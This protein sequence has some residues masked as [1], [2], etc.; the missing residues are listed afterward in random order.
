[1]KRQR[2]IS[3]IIVISMCL[4]M[5]PTWAY[6]EN[7]TTTDP[8]APG[9]TASA[10]PTGTPDA[11]AS[12]SPTRDPDATAG[13]S[14]TAS[15]TGTPDATASASKTPD[16]VAGASIH[17]DPLFGGEEAK[18]L[19]KAKLSEINV[20]EATH[21]MV[22][23]WHATNEKGQ[24]SEETGESRDLHSVII[25]GYIVPSDDSDDG[26]KYYAAARSGYHGAEVDNGD[27]FI[28]LSPTDKQ[29]G[30][31]WSVY[32]GTVG[33][34]SI[35][36]MECEYGN[37]D[38]TDEDEAYEHFAGFN[39]SSGANATVTD[40]NNGD[41]IKV[42]YDKDVHIV[43]MH[44]FYICETMDVNGTADKTVFGNEGIEKSKEHDTA[45][46][47]TYLHDSTDSE[48]S[49]IKG[50]IVKNG[51][52]PC[53]KAEELPVGLNVGEDVE[54]TKVYSTAVGLHTD[55]TAS[56]HEEYV[57]DEEGNRVTDDDGHF[58]KT[59]GDGRTFNVDLESWYT[60]GYAQQVGMVIDASG[61]MGFAS[62]IPNAINVKD[63]IKKLKSSGREADATALE[64][65]IGMLERLGEYTKEETTEYPSKANLKGYY[66]FQPN[67]DGDNRTWF[68]NTVKKEPSTKYSDMVKSDFAKAVSQPTDD[69]ID[70]GVSNQKTLIKY[71]DYTGATSWGGVPLNFSEGQGF[72]LDY[73]TAG[74]LVEET[75][76]SD[77]FTLSFSLNQT[78][79][80][81]YTGKLEILYIGGLTGSIAASKYFHVYR[82]G[83]DI[84]AEL[85]KDSKLFTLSNVYG[86]IAS[87][88]LAF[89]FNNGS[90]TAYLDGAEKATASVT[91]LSG[92]NVVFAPFDDGYKSEKQYFYVDN[93]Y[94]YDAALT[95][96]EIRTL[97]S[98]VGQPLSAPKRMVE[99][100]LTKD[101]QDIILNPRNTDNSLLGASGY[102]Y[103]VY[104]ARINTAE[105]TP[106]CYYAGGAPEFQNNINGNGWYYSSYTG[107]FTANSTT[108][109][110]TIGLQSGWTFTDTIT[111][112]TSM[113][114]DDG[115]GVA[116]DMTTESD[117]GNTGI[118]YTVSANGPIKFYIDSNGY[119]RC[120]TATG[121]SN[122]RAS[123][124]YELTDEQYVKTEAL[125]RAVGA[126][127]TKMGE[128]SPSAIVSAVRFSS[129]KLNE[130]DAILL[131][132]TSN[133]S[134]S[135]NTVSTNRGNGSFYAKDN[136]GQSNYGLTGG[137]SSI[138]GLT[139]FQSKL[140]DENSDNPDIPKYLIIFT[141]GADDNVNEPDETKNIA[142]TLKE[143]GYTIF[144]VLLNGGPV[145]ETGQQYGKAHD[146]LV[147]LSGKKGSSKADQ[148]AHFFSVAK[149]KKEL[150]DAAKGMNDADILTQIFAEE[151]LDQIIKP[152]E[153]FT[154]TEYIDP[155]FDLVDND[156]TV[157]QLKADGKVVKLA[158]DGKTE[159]IDVTTGQDIK[160]ELDNDNTDSVARK[161]Y[162]RYDS[163]K[164]ESENKGMY[165]LEWNGQTIPAS[166]IGVN[167]LAIWNARI[168]LR[169]KENFV[170]GN[171]IP[172]GGNEEMQNFVRHKTDKEPHSDAED[173]IRVFDDETGEIINHPSKGFPRVMVNVPNPANGQNDE[174]T[175]FMGEK[176]SLND[177]IGQVMTWEGSD[178]R[179]DL[180]SGIYW[181][182]ILRYTF[183][184]HSSM[185]YNDL[186]AVFETAEDGGRRSF[187]IPYYYLPNVAGNSA[188]ENK[189][190]TGTDLHR[191]DRMGYLRYTWQVGDRRYPEVTDSNPGELVRDTLPRQSTLS[192]KFTPY[193]EEQRLG[194][195]TFKISYLQ[196]L[197]KDD[198]THII[199]E[200]LLDNV[201]KMTLTNILSKD[202][203]LD[204]ELYGKVFAEAKKRILDKDG[205]YANDDKTFSEVLKNVCESVELDGGAHL[206]ETR[207]AEINGKIDANDIISMKA[208][209]VNG[210]DNSLIKDTAYRWDTAYK[211]VE[212]KTIKDEAA[213]KDTIRRNI[214]SGKVDLR[215][216]VGA[217]E[218]NKLLENDIIKT[219]TTI[220]YTADLYR[221]GKELGKLTANYTVKGKLTEDEDI[222]ATLELTDEQFIHDYGT[223]EY[224]NGWHRDEMSVGKLTYDVPTYGLPKGTYTIKNMKGE[225]SSDYLDFA[226]ME[227]AEITS[228]DAGAI[229]NANSGVL[230]SL[231]RNDRYRVGDKI[232]R[233]S[234][235]TGEQIEVEL[236]EGDPEVGT[237]KPD[238]YPDYSAFPAAVSGSAASIGATINERF[239]LFNVDIEP[240]PL[241]SLTVSKTVTGT[242]GDKNKEFTFTLDVHD[243]KIDGEFANMTFK[244]GKA[245]FKL[246]DGQS[247][248]ITLP[249]G[250]K[251]TV[252]ESNNDGYT[253]TTKGD[254]TG[255]IEEDVEAE[256]E[257]E[258][259]LDALG[260]LTVSKTVKGDL[261]D[262]NKKFGF[263]VVL[264]NE[265]I[266]GKYGDMTFK[267]GVTEFELKD[268][269]SKTAKNLPAGITY[270]VVESVTDKGDYTVDSI[271]ASG[272]IVAG[273][274]AEA[275]F[276]NT[277]NAPVPDPKG[278]LKISKTV[279]GTAGNKNKNFKF[280]LT[281]GDKSINGELGGLTFVDGVAEF[282]LKDNESITAMLP[283][284]ITYKV[285]EDNDGYDV[286][287]TGVEGTI[288][289]KETVTAEFINKLDNP[290]SPKGNLTVS[291]TVTGD[292]GEQNKYFNFIV[293]LDDESINGEYG[294]MTFENGVATF[295]L[296]HGESIT[297]TDLPAGITYEVKESET[298]RGDYTAT[299]SDDTGT[300]EDGKT[301][302]AKF[303]N[304]FNAVVPDPKGILTVSKTVTG[305]GDKT[306]NFTFTLTLGDESING[307]FGGLTFVN[308]VTEFKLK[309]GEKQIATLP[310][311]IT[312]KVEE[313]DNDG[314][315][316]TSSGD[317]TGMIEPD[318]PKEVKF[319]NHKSPE[320]SPTPSPEVSPK[321]SPEVSPTP[322]PEVS[323]KP[324]PSPSP[325]PSPDR[326]PSRNNSPK[327]K[328]VD[329][330]YISIRVEKQW[331][332]NN[333]AEGKRPES[334]TVNVM[335]GDEI[336]ATH[337]LSA[338]NNWIYTF[339]KLAR[340]ANG[341]AINYTVEEEPVSG[342]TP[343]YVKSTTGYIIRN[344]YTGEDGNTR[345]G[346]NPN[347]GKDDVPELNH[348]DHHAYIIGYPEGDVRPNNQITRAEVATIFFRLLTDDSRSKYWNQFNSF[349]DVDLINWYNNGVSTMANA[350]IVSGYLDGT[351]LPNAPI[352][353]AEFAS[354]A[355]RF[356]SGSYEGEDKFTDISDHWAKEYINRAAERGWISGYE[357]GTFRPTQPIIRSEAMTLI[358]NMLNR[359]PANINAL[360]EGMITWSD[361]LD[362][363]AWY[364]SAVQEATNSHYWEFEGDDHE[365][366]TE[367]REVRDWE[368]LEKTDSTASSA[369]A[370]DSIYKN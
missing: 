317:D 178:N 347:N 300:I 182:Y 249:A 231:I 349:S 345:P 116:P 26:Y 159:T 282:T 128:V 307:E 164:D 4:S 31:I 225:T 296:K 333:N 98:I 247:K 136:N 24:S 195:E 272:T 308:G 58:V 114:G 174:Q 69:A 66:E 230:D 331:K 137:T 74:F 151:I 156:G 42:S 90:V 155:R 210:R 262:P 314:Y 13:P 261:G 62:D 250:F 171:M 45:W 61:S 132:W 216:S 130:N 294:D 158:K 202:D 221:D 355:A 191:G 32:L 237:I 229:S 329:S 68:L 52:M 322:S 350:E 205:T 324:T 133:L 320:E 271:G 63:V 245:T 141:D 160:I 64:Y 275:D 204:E 286:T 93:I 274:T 220:K 83:N 177:I 235:E 117:S 71:Q 267:K 20:D 273:K 153:D 17:A 104:D 5:M 312:Y 352:T 110:N 124:V 144:T 89:V 244:K 168:I 270:G 304:K 242:A 147:S 269:D 108:A 223:S 188:D 288:V 60:E 109:K 284:N 175:I 140:A 77:N 295:T 362:T 19:P 360:L 297:A 217:K 75:P 276:T 290:V 142:N 318:S 23:H 134:E 122:Y 238:Y 209:N 301:A 185:S 103:F 143:A 53:T 121:S 55:K 33:D 236:Q 65:K 111:A 258:N 129:S 166:A 15:P 335:N 306:K 170:G 305:D 49:Y 190:Q 252:T 234:A 213:I 150:G 40:E 10:L 241:G 292:L 76:A 266:N 189:S 278:N 120:F 200:P 186:L 348:D 54:L 196:E 344:E 219:G 101:E 39:V 226:D 363:S 192:V 113:T 310:A 257:F 154:I 336:V 59:I 44:A 47:Y 313:S 342:Y 165:Y 91:G 27:Q 173:A 341:K 105:Y 88:E 95:A 180:T 328:D 203:K 253:V 214:V 126:F 139:A 243:E 346:D 302:E 37:W 73:S 181:E 85:G 146:F 254:T 79:A 8:A 106:I 224:D 187:I 56:V 14:K 321:P 78:A 263:T 303:T 366:W 343:N 208:S 82:T 206:D 211:P 21:F 30:G 1:M 332:D 9:V 368:A 99:V 325:T 18:N 299:S 248:T 36:L 240:A 67:K 337:E 334:I 232:T 162:L 327:Y 326:T 289:A 97:T 22:R 367:M 107:N 357:D 152:L 149:G 358:N 157:W 215:M 260:N 38:G 239:A 280:T 311:E 207:L 353:R 3:I 145:Q 102:S 319:T 43:K 161:P 198:N 251:Y 359:K 51:D 265:D 285:T 287:S 338:S 256:V 72:S 201:L 80:N 131:N 50:E 281:L 184:P 25:D 119:L 291:K 364:Y 183:S 7:E 370:W 246:K 163:G 259:H 92:K 29:G 354:I 112:G 6:A 222:Y 361:N 35:E 123:Y 86:G 41:I 365:I 127:V 169:A 293:T 197:L 11:I 218:I 351:F 194:D 81:A 46:V 148:E 176:L 356:D 16:A 48:N 125:R 12:A 115:V 135:V 84:V 309:H 172:T 255:T 316:V 323:P 264:N 179:D 277:L 57:L 227:N 138:T 96:S 34:G 70:F 283:A 233:T 2:F 118:T 193:T 94:L 199:D 268:G 340:T 369:G 100:F 228:A 298:D 330:E 28:V 212:G 315:D 279:T 87:H 167:R 339:T